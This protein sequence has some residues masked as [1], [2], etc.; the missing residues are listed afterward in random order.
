MLF[1]SESLRC[2]GSPLARASRPGQGLRAAGNAVAKGEQ[3]E[4]ANSAG[5]SGRERELAG[6]EFFLLD[7]LQASDKERKIPSR[8]FGPAEAHAM[9]RWKWRR[10]LLERLISA[11]EMADRSRRTSNKRTTGSKRRR[12]RFWRPKH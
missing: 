3:I 2:L 6:R 1:E 5:G 7:R 10:K 8:R 4:Q 11:M 12:D 9:T